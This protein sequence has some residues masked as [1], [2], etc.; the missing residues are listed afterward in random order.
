MISGTYNFNNDGKANV[1]HTIVMVMMTSLIQEECRRPGYHYIQVRELNV[2]HS[3]RPGYNE[4]CLSGH[5]K[6]RTPAY[7]PHSYGTKWYSFTFII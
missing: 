4:V 6:I 3:N 1:R 7:N 5:L 2:S